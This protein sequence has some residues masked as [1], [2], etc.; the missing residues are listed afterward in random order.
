MWH[1]FLADLLVVLHLAFVLFAVFG[2]LLAVRWK[3]VVWLHLPAVLWAGLV[4]LAGWIC[5]L[6]PLENQLRFK[7]GA[8]GYAGDFVSHYLL[9]VLYPAGLTRT[10]QVILGALVLG[11]NILIYWYVFRYVFRMRK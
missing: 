2:G 3:R 1:R 5:P 6:T 9:F 10:I 11:L 4:E 7:A 8:S